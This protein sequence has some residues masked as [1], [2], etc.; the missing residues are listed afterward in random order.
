[1]NIAQRTFSHWPSLPLWC[2][3]CTWIQYFNQG[4]FNC[5]V[6]FH[7]SDCLKCFHRLAWT[8]KQNEN[9][10][11]RAKNPSEITCGR[12]GHDSEKGETIIHTH[13]KRLSV[14]SE[15]HKSMAKESYNITLH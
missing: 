6:Y 14:L 15:E 8:L 5:K 1:M 13:K 3:L 7:H 12:V 4:H 10:F 2:G 11:T 9:P